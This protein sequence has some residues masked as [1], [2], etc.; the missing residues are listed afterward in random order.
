ME[1]KACEKGVILILLKLKRTSMLSSGDILSY[2]TRQ[3][4]MGFL[5]DHEM[6]SFGHPITWHNLSGGYRIHHKGQEARA[7]EKF[8][9]GAVPG[10]KSMNYW[11]MIK[12]RLVIARIVG[13]L[14]SCVVFL[15]QFSKRRFLIQE[16]PWII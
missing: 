8:A 7:V 10:I 12:L 9:Y 5:G 4:R 11:R 14:F 13:F 16:P 6:Q 15:K 3:K 2:L 1:S